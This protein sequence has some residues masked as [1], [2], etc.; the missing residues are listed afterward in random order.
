MHWFVQTPSMGIPGLTGGQVPGFSAKAKGHDLRR[1]GPGTRGRAGPG[2]CGGGSP[3]PDGSSPTP[4][5]CPLALPPARPDG[6]ILG[7][8][9]GVV[10]PRSP[11]AQPSTQGWPVQDT[12]PR[13]AAPMA[14][15]APLLPTA[16]ADSP[17]HAL[18]ARG[19][20]SGLV[21]GH[22]PPRQPVPRLRGALPC[23][24]AACHQLW[25]P[26]SAP[27]CPPLRHSRASTVLAGSDGG[28]G[29][30]VSHPCVCGWRSQIPCLSTGRT[31]TVGT[32][33]HGAVFGAGPGMTPLGDSSQARGREAGRCPPPGLA[34]AHGEA[35]LAARGHGAGPHRVQRR[36]LN[37]CV[38]GRRKGRAWPW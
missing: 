9:H 22:V 3:V 27:H 18:V 11:P 31:G 13:H 21:R 32:L 12:Q 7:R 37:P 35:E 23:C 28:T 38:A 2:C 20:S 33:S 34:A 24:P 5:L 25:A 17:G 29:A 14:V 15:S 6:D 4:Q 16:A 26:G 36:L 19:L 30:S 1:A 8:P 10:L